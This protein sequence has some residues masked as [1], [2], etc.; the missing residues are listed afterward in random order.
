MSNRFGREHRQLPHCIRLL[1]ENQPR[2]RQE[3]LIRKALNP[4]DADMYFDN[5]GRFLYDTKCIA[6]ELERIKVEKRRALSLVSNHAQFLK[7]LI[8]G[9]P[10]KP[11]V[12]IASM[13]AR[14]RRAQAKASQSLLSAD[15]SRSE[16]SETGNMKP[17][18]SS[19]TVRRSPR[20]SS[21]ASFTSTI[22]SPTSDATS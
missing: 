2:N 8:M 14:Y 1:P 13:R 6:Q 3:Y 16:D 7:S 4:E 9:E 11:Q 10:E 19:A 22:M 12:D 5:A 15:V 18:K 17:K 20:P 21:S